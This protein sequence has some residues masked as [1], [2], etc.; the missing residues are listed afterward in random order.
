MK[1]HLALVLALVMVLGS[2]SFVSAA[3]D[4]PDVKDTTFEEAVG[5]L[6]L[7]DILKGY[8]DG[9][10]KPANTITR[11]EFAAVAVRVSGLEQAAMSA[12]GLPTGFSDV[13]AWHWA[14]G[15]V[16][17]AGKLGIVNGIGGGLFAPES[18]VKYEEAIT[19]LVRAL[20]YE[21][22]AQAKGG[23]PFGYL[24]VANEIDLLD[25]ALGTQGTWATR[26]FVA[27]ITFNALEI[28]MMIQSGYGTD[29][30]FVVSG[31][32]GT[33]EKY[34]IEQMG[35]KSVE[36]R[37]TDYDVDDLEIAMTVE[38]ENDVELRD[39]KEKTYDV[40]E[41]FDF[42]RVHGVTVKAWVEGDK[43]LL[44]KLV[45]KVMFDATEFDADDE[46][47]TLVYV[48]KDYKLEKDA[49]YF[50]LNDSLKE[51]EDDNFN[52]DYAKVVMDG[53]KVVWADGVEFDEFVVFKEASK[54]YLVD[55]ND[56]EYDVKDYLM[57]KDGKTIS[58][59]ALEAGDVVFLFNNDY[60]DYDGLGVVA[61]NKVEGVV[62]K[63]YTNSFRLD[64]D[65]Y[66]MSEIDTPQYLDDE[67]QDDIDQ[68]VLSAFEDEGEKIKVLLDFYGDVVLMD[69]TRDR[70]SV[71]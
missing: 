2:F 69:G 7:L 53:N 9:T 22:A 51:W 59:D 31:T 19:M 3:P 27:Q 63:A 29:S 4:F 30:R 41:G 17:T 60:F 12:K 11:A 13:P 15:Y 8:P 46:E 71:V 39:A 18:P 21:P 68:D 5:S 67:D 49:R 33:K 38:K 54:N 6:E 52:A 61:T 56:D 55:F 64:G 1:K 58:A 28:E 66:E 37:V 10:F 42:Y 43:V 20:G 25:G 14:S 40:V 50:Y 70:K 47:V 32:D 36:G 48:D 24:I 65:T 26:G 16:G 44:T 57:V 35:F 45:D 23:Y 62:T 34:L